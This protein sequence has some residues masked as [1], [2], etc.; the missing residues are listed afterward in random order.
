VIGL[1]V[2]AGMVIWG[3]VRLFLDTWR[4]LR[5]KRRPVS[6]EHLRFDQFDQLDQFDRGSIADEAEEWLR[7]R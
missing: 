2:V 3:G 5:R 6:A 1:V 7:S 4:R